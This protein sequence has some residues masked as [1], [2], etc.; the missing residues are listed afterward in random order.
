ME[1]MKRNQ[2]RM[3]NRKKPPLPAP[4]VKAQSQSSRT[5]E[6]VC[7][8]INQY[9]KSQHYVTYQYTAHLPDIDL[10]NIIFLRPPFLW[11]WHELLR[12]C[13]RPLLWPE[14]FLLRIPRLSLTLY[15][16]S[17]SHRR[18]RKDRPSRVEKTSHSGGCCQRAPIKASP[19]QKCTRI[20]PGKRQA[21]FRVRA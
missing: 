3:T 16:L 7:E 6:E 10:I 21:D 20:N 4:G 11:G 9:D 17:R 1:R 13:C 14:G 15:C 2:E 18:C 19:Q 12:P 8:L 5:Q